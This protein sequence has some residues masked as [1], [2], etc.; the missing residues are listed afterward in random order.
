MNEVII[1]VADGECARFYRVVPPD[2]PRVRA[3]LE[4]T[5]SL[6]HPDSETRPSTA[7]QPA[8]TISNRQAGPVHPVVAQ[9]ERHRVEHDR[10]F[11]GDI[12][13]AAA[14]ATQD[15]THG[16]VVLVAGP[17]MLGLLRAPLRKA[18][19]PGIGL[20]E[21]ARDYAQLA[22]SDLYGYLADKGIVPAR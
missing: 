22:P 19:H 8:E 4:E 11:A 7:G 17:R 6:Q 14:A 1:I 10:R 21:I 2:G 12:T 13:R 18:L 5:A 9:R 3:Q 20:K 15:W 16:A